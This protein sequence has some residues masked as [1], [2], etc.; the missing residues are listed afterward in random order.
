MVLRCS[1]TEI[2][3]MRTLG[4]A[5]KSKNLADETLLSIFDY[6]D[7]KELRAVRLV[8]RQFSRP[9]NT[10]LYQVVYFSPRRPSMQALSNISQH[11]LFKSTVKHVIYDDTQLVRALTNWKV[12][13]PAL[14]ANTPKAQARRAFKLYCQLFDEQESILRN[15]EDTLVLR[16]AFARLPNLEKISVTG[17]PSRHPRG[18]TYFQEG[19]QAQRFTDT[20]YGLSYWSYHDSDEEQRYQFW[21]R[22]PFHHLL[23]AME[24]AKVQLKDLHIG[25]TW[26]STTAEPVKMGIPLSSLRDLDSFK[27]SKFLTACKSAFAHLTSLDLQIDVHGRAL[28]HEY[29]DGDMDSLF[30]ILPFAERLRSLS[31]GFTHFC[32]HADDTLNVLVNKWPA[33]QSVRFC[34]MEVA[35]GDLLKFF[36]DH[37]ETLKNITLH[38]FG[39][40]A[41]S[42]RSW[43]QLA[44]SAR[45]VLRFERAD[46]RVYELLDDDDALDTRL[47]HWGCP[48]MAQLT[49]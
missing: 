10:L 13:H 45:E 38:D 46:V 41:G 32:L 6:L 4:A 36:D 23:K 7:R 26:I 8:C 28:G 25:N 48:L 14:P 31:L 12:F 39:L 21:D 22:R 11:E 34:N 20:L 3:L 37:K 5:C 24:L 2:V 40:R 16:K 27:N 19:A 42:D 33:L 1:S 29:Y 9:G 44:E 15:G 47:Y 17:G 43:M 18:V 35:V 49:R 30:E